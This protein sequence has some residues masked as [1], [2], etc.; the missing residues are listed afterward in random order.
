MQVNTFV[1]VNY[2][3]QELTEKCILSV[4]KHHE[5]AKIIVFDNSDSQPFIFNDERVHIIDNTKNDKIDFKQEITQLLKSNNIDT[6]SDT[7]GSF[8]H[9]ITVQ[10]LFNL[11]DE[12]FVLLDSDILLKKPFI[13]EINDTDIIVGEVDNERVKPFA[14]TINLKLAKK[15]SIIFCDYKHILP[16]KP[17]PEFDTG[18]FFRTQ[19]LEKHLPYANI[20]LNDYIVHYKNGSWAERANQMFNLK[21]KTPLEWLEDN[22]HLW[23]IHRKPINKI[24]VLTCSTPNRKWLYDITNQTKQ[25]YCSKN[26]IDFI[27][28]DT[29]YPD[30]ERHPYWNKIKMICDY[31]PDYEWVVWLDDDAGF[32]RDTTIEDVI[33]TAEAPFMFCEDMNGFNSGVMF[34]KNTDLMQETFEFIWNKMY[35]HYKNHQF[36]EQDALKKVITDLGVGQSINAHLYNAYDKSLTICQQNQATDDTIILHI[37]GGTLFKEQHRDDIRRLYESYK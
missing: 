8:K 4:L 36:P 10:Y 27:F 20:D 21:R 24:A 26:N 15:E 3:T 6:V 13:N 14:V 1:I 7:F 18:G 25:K 37:A 30:R 12:N 33:Q 9:A 16:I 29:F 2:N 34:V 19:I 32:I 11:L 28:S 31:L 35:H 22:K 23:K 5:N 17:I